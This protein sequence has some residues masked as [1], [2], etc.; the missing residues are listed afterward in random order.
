M[1]LSIGIFGNVNHQTTYAG[2]HVEIY[3][4]ANNKLIFETDSAKKAYTNKDTIIVKMIN[5]KIKKYYPESE[6]IFKYSISSVR[7]YE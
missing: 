3:K 1:M 6:Y 5:G 2:K 7:Y 4:K